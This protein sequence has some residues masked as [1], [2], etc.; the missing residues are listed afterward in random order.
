MHMVLHQIWIINYK[1]KSKGCIVHRGWW[2]AN[3][4]AKCLMLDQIWLAR[5]GRLIMT[6]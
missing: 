2:R 3:S 1:Y 5:L 4:Y 6:T